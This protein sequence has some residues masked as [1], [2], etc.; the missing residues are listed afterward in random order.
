MSF[1]TDF[2]ERTAYLLLSLFFITL[3][4]LK[5]SIWWI[6]SRC[7]PV[8]PKVISCSHQSDAHKGSGNR[9]PL[10]KETN[11]L[12]TLWVS[13]KGR[14]LSSAS[15]KRSWNPDSTSP[16]PACTHPLCTQ[17]DANLC[18]ALLQKLLCGKDREIFCQWAE[19]RLTPEWGGN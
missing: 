3:S 19:H 2:T 7:F 13:W 6:R 15:H 16:Q 17:R 5:S 10:Q 18:I 1:H 12:L 4:M 8:L 11:S 14:S 9:W